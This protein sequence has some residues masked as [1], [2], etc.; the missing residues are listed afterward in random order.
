MVIDYAPPA[1]TPAPRRFVDSAE[2]RWYRILAMRNSTRSTVVRSTRRGVTLAAVAVVVTAACGGGSTTDDT[3]AT[4]TIGHDALEDKIRG[5]WAG[6]MIGVS[7]G[8]PTEFK[9]NGAI[10][11]GDLPVW[12]PDRVS[13]AIDQDDLYVEMTFAGVMDRQG[14]DAT[15]KQYGEAFRD[16]E[17]N[18][19]HANAAAR[20]LLAIG[21]EAPMSG[22][23][24]YNAHANDIDFQ[25]ESDF[26]GLMTPGL[27]QEAITYCERVGRVMN[28]GDGLYGGMF[29]TGMYA[30]A[31]FETDP[32]RVVEAGVATLPPESGYARIIRDVLSWHRVHPADWRQTWQL[33]EDKWDR[34]DACPAGSLD[35]FNIDARLNG[36]YIALGLLYGGGDMGRTLEIST[37]A[38]Q[39]SDCNPS[40]AAGILGVMLGFDAIPDVWRSGI[41][42]LHDRKFAYTDY[43]FDDIVRSTRDRALEVVR[44]AGGTV[45]DDGIVVPVQ[46]AA[47][48]PP[49]E[50]WDM[51]TP[52]RRIAVDDEAWTW[53]GHWAAI[54]SDRG[55]ARRTEKTGA[56]AELAFAGTAVSVRGRYSQA[57]GRADVYLDGT[58]VGALDAWIPPRT[59]DD[60]LWHTYDLPPGRHTLRIVTSGEADPRSTG[61]TVELREAIIYGTNK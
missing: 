6:Q 4:R 61:R 3:A 32:R 11:E 56:E 44:R 17:Y 26:I 53:R 46:A 54:D 35:P 55:A 36:A 12:T 16:S 51:G 21:V 52:V 5:G 39:D 20:R 18:L 28:H 47:S 33:I 19:W 15:T 14:L 49:L 31:F 42:D 57:G 29:V 24:L 43:S 25:I 23:P 38:G 8:A 22:H 9:S 34:D 50:Q 45:T 59:S 10:I 30:A 37:R 7:F 13:N 60:G 2:A 1:A 27:P 40:S 41:A 48:P 58:K